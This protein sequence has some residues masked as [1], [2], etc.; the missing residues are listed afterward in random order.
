MQVVVTVVIA[1]A[2]C[3]PCNCPP[4]APPSHQRCVAL[5]PRRTCHGTHVTFIKACRYK[6]HG[7]GGGHTATAII[8]SGEQKLK[9]RH[10]NDQV[11]KHIKARLT[12][13][14]SQHTGRGASVTAHT[15]CRARHGACVKAHASQRTRDCA[16]VKAHAS[17]RTRQGDS[18]N[19][20]LRVR[21]VARVTAT[22][23]GACVT[24]HVLRS[25]HTFHNAHV[26]AQHKTAHASR[27]TRHVCTRLG[28]QVEA[29][30]S[31]VTSRASRRT[32]HVA[33]VTA[34]HASRRTRQGARVT[35]YASRRR[36]TAHASRRRHT[37]HGV[38]VKA[39][40]LQYTL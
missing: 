22:C 10:T 27:R 19:A 11:A 14:A 23:H 8:S 39:H 15:P 21:H 25:R 37:R 20:C 16:C 5:M 28:A 3:R 18:A 6:R 38:R 32:L 34:A 30:A 13:H 7:G 29:H 4:G 35:L 33:H 26:T 12:A 2:A 9:A 40:A 31:R 1:R 17:R 24:A 36:V